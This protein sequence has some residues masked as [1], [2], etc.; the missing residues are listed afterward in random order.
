MK[1]AYVLLVAKSIHHMLHWKSSKE[2]KKQNESRIHDFSV[3]IAKEYNITHI[4]SERG[5]YA[6]PAPEKLP[7]LSI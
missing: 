3:F 5:V 2:E 7:K 6:F 4:L 1:I